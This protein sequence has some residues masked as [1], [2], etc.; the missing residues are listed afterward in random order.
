MRVPRPI[1]KSM[2][3][4]MFLKV[5]HE[6]LPGGTYDG[7]THDYNGTVRQKLTRF[8]EIDPLSDEERGEAL[9]GVFEL[10]R[11]G[12]IM[13]DPTQRNPVFK[14]VTEK[15]E[16]VVDQELEDMTL[17]GV[18]I[19]QLLTRD[20]LRRLVHDDYIEGDYE[21]AVFKAFRHLEELVRSK[22]GLQAS[23]IGVDLMSKA[24]NP[25]NGILSHPDAQATSE[26]HGF[27]LLLRGSI[28][29]FKNPS[30]HRTMGYHDPEEAA[31]ILAF[32]N[33]LLDLVDQC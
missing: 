28:Q 9:R 24:F 4:K 1:P 17:S 27:H 21:T 25:G 12:F 31:H 2:L 8:F 26:Q 30:T 29:W 14:V 13:Q 33:L 10:E 19:D 11:D 3:K 6:H 22:A 16:D 23:D 18:D 32:A 5:L 15:G 20:D 7:H